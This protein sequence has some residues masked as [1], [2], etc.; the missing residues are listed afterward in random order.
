MREIF[1]LT[2]QADGKCFLYLSTPSD[3]QSQI[4]G[5]QLNSDDN[6]LAET[7]VTKQLLSMLAEAYYA[8][9]TESVDD[10]AEAVKRLLLESKQHRKPNNKISERTDYSK[11]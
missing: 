1:T 9:Y 10:A 3:R 4:C 7:D 2:T 8:G 6:P 5:T 11:I